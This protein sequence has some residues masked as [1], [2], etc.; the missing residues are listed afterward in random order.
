MKFYKFRKLRIPSRIILA[1]MAERN[2][3]VSLVMTEMVV[4]LMTFS[5]QTPNERTK[6]SREFGSSKTINLVNDVDS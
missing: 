5:D 4:L 6:G 3:P 2:S 1:A